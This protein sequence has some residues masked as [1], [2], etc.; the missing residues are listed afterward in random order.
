MDLTEGKISKKLIRFTIPVIVLQFLNQAYTLTDNIVVARFVGEESLSVLSTVNSCLLVAYCLMQGFS[1]ATSILAA[2]LFG[3]HSYARLR[4]MLRTILISVAAISTAIFLIYGI[5]AMPIFRLLSVPETIQE[6]CHSLIWVYALTL[7]PTY[8]C[9]I[10]TSALNG[11]G[12]SKTPMFISTGSQIL[13]IVLDILAVAVWNFG[14]MGAAVASL[15]SVCV[16]MVLTAF[17]LRKTLHALPAETENGCADSQE[18]GAFCQYMNL[19]IPSILQQSILSIGTLLLQ[20]L[21]NTAGVDYING[22]T[23]ATTL[24]SLLLLP[25]VS[26]CIGY[27]TFAAQNL[28]AKKKDRVRSGFFGIL[29]SGLLVCVV[30]SLATWVFSKPL[31]G[32]Y[33]TDPASTSFAFARLFFLLLIPN[34]F[35]TLF[36]NSMDGIFKAKQ[37]VYLFTISSL[38]AFGIRIV[39][40]YALAPVWG[41][42]ALAYATAIGNFCAVILDGIFLRRETKAA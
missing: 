28:G 18:K 29:A 22:Y 42:S 37:K 4:S 12:D 21:V 32:L 15:F 3:S 5:F 10:C 23:V 17:F 25:I 7:P 1:S 19:A 30:L 27:E 26:C 38:A 16:A 34:Y 8:L 11:M 9:S 14:V 39:L 2:N 33:L 31:V 41:L 13:N 6:Q 35:L 36:K 20:R 24:N 40:G